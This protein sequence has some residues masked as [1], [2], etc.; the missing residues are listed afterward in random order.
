VLL[1]ELRGA[2]EQTLHFNYLLPENGGAL[3][4]AHSTEE[5]LEHLRMLVAGDPSGDAWRED[6]LSSFVRPHGIEEPAA[7]RLVDDL[8]RLARR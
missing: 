4:V 8:E 3:M 6:F 2:Q 5:H 7:P 1:P